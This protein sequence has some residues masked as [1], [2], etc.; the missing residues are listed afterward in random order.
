MVALSTKLILLLIVIVLTTIGIIMSLDPKI[1]LATIATP[2]IIETQTEEQYCQ[3]DHEPFYYRTVWNSGVYVKSEIPDCSMF[4]PLKNNLKLEDYF[5]TF[6]S[7]TW[8][9]LNNA[10]AFNSIR[11]S[12]NI[13][14][15]TDGMKIYT[16]ENKDPTTNST[17]KWTCGYLVS[18]DTYGYG[19]YE[20]HMRYTK[21]TGIN[22]AFWLNTSRYTDKDMNG[23]DR[24][25]I[26]EFD[27]NEGKFNN[28][29]QSSV[30]TTVHYWGT[31]RAPDKK[32]LYVNEDLSNKYR[33][34]QCLY[35]PSKI[36][37]Y[38]DHVLVNT[39]SAKPDAPWNEKVW[40]RFSTAVASFA[41][42]E[43]SFERMNGASMDVEF[44][45]YYAL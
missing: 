16:F 40:V 31:N 7:A 20:A 43:D 34:Y 11:M 9:K 2:G 36:L 30:H 29:N 41:G 42:P 6:N 3:E 21:A 19:F 5:T 13:K 32:I 8:N 10:P 18:T 27:V 39:I 15:G 45:R 44:F 26:D 12:D 33:T 17:R 37:F 25:R 23:T 22:N 28:S 38:V 35:T 24:S 4:L 14:F 1:S